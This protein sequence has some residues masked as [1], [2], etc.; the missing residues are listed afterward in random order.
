M[1]KLICIQ[2]I[3]VLIVNS[4]VCAQGDIRV[5]IKDD[6]TQKEIPYAYIYKKGQPVGYSDSTGVFSANFSSI[7]LEKDS[8]FFS[9]VGYVRVGYPISRIIKDPDIYMN[10]K[11]DTLQEI[12]V[13]VIPNR[14]ETVIGPN[15]RIASST[16]FCNDSSWG[17]IFANY[18]SFSDTLNAVTITKIT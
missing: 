6:K 14:K 5:R 13:R 17:M 11:V 12:T 18:L 15:K 3:L 10:A 4:F 9:C 2:V 8:L 16:D 7:N 1:K